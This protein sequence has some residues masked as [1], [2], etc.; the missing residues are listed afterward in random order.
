MKNR[1]MA[2]A[3]AVRDSLKEVVWDTDS[4]DRNGVIIDM[5]EV[6]LAAIIASV[7]V[8]IEPYCWMVTGTST[9]FYG[10]FA[11]VD[12]MREAKHCGGT[13][14][15]F[16]LYARP[17]NATSVRRAAIEECA[18]VCEAFGKALEVDVG[19]NFSEEIRALLDK[20]P[21]TE[22]VEPVNTSLL[23]ALKLARD[24]FAANDL[25]LP[26]T[27]SVIAEAIAAAEQ[28]PAPEGA[29]K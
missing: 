8:D 6:D 16:P 1:D 11:Q 4:D 22:V 9:P 7:P 27:H 5:D 13:A 24:M 2:I 21:A 14:K 18:K 20:E 10:E 12:A 17:Q 29:E 26:H 15:S 25:S 28:Q 3:E 19:D 23:D